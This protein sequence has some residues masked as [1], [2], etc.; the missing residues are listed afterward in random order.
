MIGN[1]P[2]PCF[3]TRYVV[4]VRGLRTG[5][6]SSMVQDWRP[7]HKTMNYWP[8]WVF[9]IDF[10]Y[11]RF[12]PRPFWT[13]DIISSLVCE[14]CW[15]HDQNGAGN[16]SWCSAVNRVVQVNRVQFGSPF[17]PVGGKS[18]GFWEL[19]G[20]GRFRAKPQACVVYHQEV[21]D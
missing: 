16:E 1:F 18:G 8:P 9:T 14:F 6:E 7:R 13:H 12:W 4:P 11:F 2:V 21:S 5:F 19:F 17:L 3:I 10:E 20:F 15:P